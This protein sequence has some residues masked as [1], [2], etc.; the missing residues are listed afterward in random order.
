SGRRLYKPG[1]GETLLEVAQRAAIPELPS[2][3]L[4]NEEALH[5]IVSR[6]LEKQRD[7]RYLSAAGMLRDLEEYAGEAHMVA[8]PI[9]CG[10]WLMS[11]F[12]QESV[13][14][15]RGRQRAL[16]ALERG[17]IAVIDPIQPTGDHAVPL[18]PGEDRPLPRGLVTPGPI[19]VTSKSS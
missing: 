11:H 15:R 10:E 9:R 5:A 2:H 8:S 4:P 12:G 19:A 1:E 18:G 14:A 3:D 13:E 17:P 16:R 7:D 6:A